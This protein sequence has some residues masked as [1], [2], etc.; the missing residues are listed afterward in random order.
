M[1]HS[2]AHFIASALGGGAGDPQGGGD[3]ARWQIPVGL[4]PSV[5]AVMG[6]M[7]SQLLEVRATESDT[8]T[9]ATR[10]GYGRGARVEEFESRSQGLYKL[11][12]VFFCDSQTLA[13]DTRDPLFVLGGV[14]ECLRL[15]AHWGLSPAGVD[16][17]TAVIYALCVRYPAAS[18]A[19]MSALLLGPTSPV[20]RGAM[21]EGDVERF[22]AAACRQEPH[23]PGRFRGDPTLNEARIGVVCLI[24]F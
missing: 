15:V 2:A 18:K 8:K 20:K 14:Q 7:G 17:L 11:K 5:D 23:K 16:A 13:N 10:I 9:G 4:N 24:A 19:A 21:G 3:D 22:V 6:E 12:G 1:V